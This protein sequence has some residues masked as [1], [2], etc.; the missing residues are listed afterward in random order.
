[1]KG[2]YSCGLCQFSSFSLKRYIMLPRMM[3]SNQESQTS[4]MSTISFHRGI[5]NKF[6]RVVSQA[7]MG[8]KKKQS[9]LAAI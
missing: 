4:A 5:K 7:K 9:Y 3:Q 1:M 6:F 8:R 2:N